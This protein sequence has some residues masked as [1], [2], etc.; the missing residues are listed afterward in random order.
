MERVGKDMNSLSGADD[1]G[2]VGHAGGELGSGVKEGECMMGVR[3]HG[4][5]T[6]LA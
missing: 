4:D 2:G 3:V 1:R 6:G 5:G